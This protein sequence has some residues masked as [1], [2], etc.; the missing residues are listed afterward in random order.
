MIEAENTNPKKRNTLTK[1]ALRVFLGFL[2][3]VIIF[4]LAVQIPFIQKRIVEYV[5]EYATTAFGIS[6]EIESVALYPLRGNFSLDGVTCT[7]DGV[8]LDFESVNLLSFRFG[9]EG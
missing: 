3:I 8:V 1:W 2:S 6:V 4:S 5:T 7:S 9:E